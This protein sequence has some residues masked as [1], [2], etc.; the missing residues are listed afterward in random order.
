[1]E[2]MRDEGRL[3]RDAPEW[4]PLIIEEITVPGIESFG[5]SSVVI[6]I[7]ATTIPLKQWEVGRELRRR[8]K[9]RFDAEG[10]EL[11]YPQR[12]LFWGEGEKADTGS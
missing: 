8:L 1:M 12:T 4:G 5:E 2:V 7:V 9:N 11:P 10:I 6:R 3:M